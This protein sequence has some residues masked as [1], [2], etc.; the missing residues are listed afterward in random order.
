MDLMHEMN[1]SSGISK[2]FSMQRPKDLK[3]CHTK[4]VRADV[5]CF[6]SL[7]K[8]GE[9]TIARYVAATFIVAGVY[10]QNF[11]MKSPPAMTLHIDFILNLGFSVSLSLLTL[12]S[13][14]YT[15]LMMHSHHVLPRK[16]SLHMTSTNKSR[17]RTPNAST[18]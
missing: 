14:V 2:K 12:V 11:I 3:I 13:N 5:L 6:L 18:P 9:R 17:E 4:K 8:C 15:P 1:G 7:A 10:F 16:R